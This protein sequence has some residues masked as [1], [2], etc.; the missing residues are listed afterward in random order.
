MDVRR[1]LLVTLAA[2]LSGCVRG[3]GNVTITTPEANSSIQQS[4]HGV[5]LLAL[6]ALSKDEE[7]LKSIKAKSA[8]AQQV[9]DAAVVPLF[10]G[11]DLSTITA[12]TATQALSL[13]DGKIDP[14]LKGV[15]QLA[16][17]GALVFVKLPANPTDKL[18]DDQRLMILGLFQGVSQG[19]AEFQSW[20][21]P[22][23]RDA[24]VIPPVRGLSWE[25]G[26]DRP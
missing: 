21:G 22:G 12:S 2:A 16:I 24:A 23:S 7:A 1:L 15:I 11:Q 26:G 25:Y 13:L 17:N 6:K 10:K 3:S 20:D 8:L 14:T 5:T 19:I 18:S 4:A 9:I